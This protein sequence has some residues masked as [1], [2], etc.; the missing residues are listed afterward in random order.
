VFF[1]KRGLK[2]R[3]FFGIPPV[4]EADVDPLSDFAGMTI[5]GYLPACV[6]GLKDLIPLFCSLSC[7]D[8]VGNCVFVAADD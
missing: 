7:Q 8:S 4:S 6:T 1:K 5:I 2:A 3:V